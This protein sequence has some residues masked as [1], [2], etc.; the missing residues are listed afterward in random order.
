MS[1]KTSG[2]FPPKS[3]FP[4]KTTGKVPGSFKENTPEPY[5]LKDPKTVFKYENP[6]TK[7][8]VPRPELDKQIFFINNLI[9][10]FV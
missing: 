9:I 2:K 10:F 1:S 4:P 7:P 6:P 8:M 5:I 3:K